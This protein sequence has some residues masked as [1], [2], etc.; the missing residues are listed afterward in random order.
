MENLR[1]GLADENFVFLSAFSGAPTLRTGGG[2][3]CDDG[4]QA[5]ENHFYKKE[6]FH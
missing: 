5:P 4:F 1:T 6:T 3:E 2:Q